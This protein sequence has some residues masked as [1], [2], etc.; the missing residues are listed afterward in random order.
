MSGTRDDG[1]RACQHTAGSEVQLV[2]TTSH[3]DEARA[4]H[5]YA[6]AG[7]VQSLA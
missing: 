7:A 5:G 6:D 2:F 4:M 3:V 1:A